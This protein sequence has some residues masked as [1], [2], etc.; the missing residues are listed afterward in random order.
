VI[1]FAL[2]VVSAVML[3]RFGEAEHG[4]GHAGDHHQAGQVSRQGLA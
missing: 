2:A 4:H 1:G 3:A